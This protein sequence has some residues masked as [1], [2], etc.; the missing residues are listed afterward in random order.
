MTSLD[1]D[2]PARRRYD[3]PVRRQR[4]AETR[5]RIV[6]AGIELLHATASWN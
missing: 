2:A 5:E 3:S 6:T 4:A 1:H